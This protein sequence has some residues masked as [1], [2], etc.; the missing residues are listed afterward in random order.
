MIDDIREVEISPLIA[1]RELDLSKNRLKEVGFLAK[2]TELEVV[3]CEIPGFK[4][5]R[6]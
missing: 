5:V 2:L 4:F 6:K 3:K 1:L